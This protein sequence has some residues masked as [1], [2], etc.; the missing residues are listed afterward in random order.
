M[1]EDV[2]KDQAE[3][4]KKK[5]ETISIGLDVGTMNL[6]AAR[7]DKDEIKITRNAKVE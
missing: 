7:S 1:T 3:E 6:C 2:K 5:G 4:T